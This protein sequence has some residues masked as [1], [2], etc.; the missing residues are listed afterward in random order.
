MSNTYVRVCSMYSTTFGENCASLAQSLFI[1][2]AVGEKLLLQKLSG[3]CPLLPKQREKS[4]FSFSSSLTCFILIKV[5][6]G[7]VGGG[8]RV[9]S[10]QRGKRNKFIWAAA[11]QKKSAVLSFCLGK[12]PDQHKP[13]S[14][15]ST[16]LLCSSRKLKAYFTF[17][18][19]KEHMEKRRDF[20]CPIY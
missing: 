6:G 16:I 9:G 5:E 12:I 8:A 13:R 10:R 14:V 4:Q 3:R 15:V 1:F 18:S 11:A 7:G 20:Y 19:V 2:A 17:F